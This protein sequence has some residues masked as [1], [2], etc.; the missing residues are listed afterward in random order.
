M[1]DPRVHV[2]WF[3]TTELGPLM[4]GEGAREIK[5]EIGIED[6]KFENVPV[7]VAFLNG[8]SFTQRNWLLF[9]RIKSIT[10]KKIEMH[11]NTWY[12]THVAMA[13]FCILVG[14]E[15]AFWASPELGFRIPNNNHA[16]RVFN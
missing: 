7:A 3:E 1:F 15:D 4:K 6:H 16:W 8:V 12:I 13:R 11:I 10:T 9:S 5:L 2:Q 14:Q